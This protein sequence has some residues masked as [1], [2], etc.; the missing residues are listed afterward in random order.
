MKFTSAIIAFAFVASASAACTMQVDSTDPNCCWGGKNG[1][2]ACFRQA[3][4]QT[5]RDPNERKNFCVNMG[6]PRS[7]CDA[8]CCDT[9]TGWG[10]PC[11]K[12]R[13]A[14][15]DPNNCPF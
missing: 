3:K 12:G 15:E 2:D 6:I 1:M 10:K 13:N 11:P 14:C 4:S 5:C 8:D 7:K 9:R